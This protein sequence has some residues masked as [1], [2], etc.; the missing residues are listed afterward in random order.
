MAVKIN[1]V[2]IFANGF[3][4]PEYLEN[5]SKKDTVICVD[6]ACIW[7][8]RQGIKADY[9]IGDFDSVTKEELAEIKAALKKIQIYPQ[10]KNAT[11]FELAVE[12][13]IHIKPSDVLI[14]GALGSRLDHSLS[15]IFL[16]ER[17]LNK[18]IQAE[19]RDLNN[20]LTLIAGSYEIRNLRQYNYF[21][22]QPLTDTAVVTVTGCR[23]PLSLKKIHRSSSLT[24]SNRKKKKNCLIKVHRG[25]VSLILS[26][27]TVNRQ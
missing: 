4:Y 18:N 8:L 19:I 6:A 11:D 15:A 17:F 20:L 25:L 14:F 21:S 10:D 16:L 5:I 9:A 13:A 22:L 23:Y 1:R 12:L 24:I 3:L 2:V 27:D 26:R 7:L